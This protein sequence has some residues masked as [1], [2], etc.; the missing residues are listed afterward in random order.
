MER[1][2]TRSH[3][4]AFLAVIALVAPAATAQTSVTPTADARATTVRDVAQRRSAP[5]GGGSY[6]GTGAATV[7]WWD[8][9]P[10]YGGQAPDAFREAMSDYLDTFMGGGVFDATFVASEIPGTSVRTPRN[11][12]SAVG[13]T[14]LRATSL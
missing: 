12:S 5:T 13:W 10:E 11:T 8:C 4:S 7:L 14:L 6:A 9:T 3:A 1:T 2:C